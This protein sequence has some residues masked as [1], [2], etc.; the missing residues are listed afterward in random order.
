ME[1]RQEEVQIT[2]VGDLVGETCVAAYQPRAR[3]IAPTCGGQSPPA[4]PSR[5][6]ARRFSTTVMSKVYC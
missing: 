3:D 4:I 6:I 2:N 1:M 5:E